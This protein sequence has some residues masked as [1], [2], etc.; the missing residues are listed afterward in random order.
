MKNV[1]REKSIS[2][3]ISNKLSTL[4]V[5]HPALGIITTLLLLPALSS[6]TDSVDPV[7]AKPEDTVM[8]TKV[9]LDLHDEDSIP[10]QIDIFAFE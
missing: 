1:C 8:T 5:H 9:M 10:G 4:N 2:S 6:C 3:T 7:S